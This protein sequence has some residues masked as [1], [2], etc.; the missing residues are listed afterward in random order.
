VQLPNEGLD[1]VVQSIFDDVAVDR[2]QDDNGVLLHAQRGGGVN[3]VAL[4]AGGFQARIDILGVVAALAVMMTSC[5][6]SASMI[7]A[8]CRVPASTPKLGQPHRP[9]RW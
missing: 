1:A 2:I 6:A 4:P 3:P 7:E 8:S 5:A 9:G